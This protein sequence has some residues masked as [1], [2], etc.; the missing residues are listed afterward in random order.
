MSAAL[1]T[2]SENNHAPVKPMDAHPNLT[3]GVARR[4]LLVLPAMAAALGIGGTASAFELGAM[5]VHSTLG[6]PLRASIAYALNPHEEISSYCIYLGPGRSATGLPSAGQASVVVDNGVIRLAGTAAV[7]DPLLALQLTVDCPYAAHLS[8]E[9]V[10]FIDP[11]AAVSAAEPVNVRA[12]REQ[13]RPA[14]AAAEAP[15]ARASAAARAPI[16]AST[17]YRVQPGDTLSGIAQRL[18]GRSITIWQAVEAL[19]AANPDAF[20]GGNRDFLK[21]GAVLRVPD[22]IYGAD[23]HPIARPATVTQSAPAE[24]SSPPAPASTAYSGYRSASAQIE[25]ARAAREVAPAARS[26]AGTPSPVPAAAPARDIQA[27]DGPFVGPAEP[28]VTG[29]AASAERAPAAVLPEGTPFAPPLARVPAESGGA[30]SWLIWL[31]GSGIALILALLLGRPLR[32]RFDGAAEVPFIGERPATP[33]ESAPPAVTRTPEPVPDTSGLEVDFHFGEAEA[34]GVELDGDV[35]NGSG[36]QGSGEL[37]IAQDFGFSASD[38]LEL[39]LDIEFPEEQPAAEGAATNVLPTMAR[40]GD[41]IVE[42][43]VPPGSEETGEYDVSMIVD[44]TQ[45]PLPDDTTRDLHAIELDTGEPAQ[46]EEEDPFTL[47]RE[48][49]YK[50]LEQDYQEELTATQALNSRLEDAARDL[51]L[52]LGADEAASP[53]A[54]TAEFPT[55][56]SD[57]T[58]P[59]PTTA[60]ALAEADTVE[61][62]ATSDDE[63]TGVN[64]E[65]KDYPAA[66]ND[67]TAEMETASASADTAK[68]KKVS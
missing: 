17:A 13:V 58:A 46:E 5:E 38:G 9:Y 3:P 7:S 50:I 8:R 49:D 67:A 44:A 55:L 62:P 68:K 66:V 32:K 16:A 29:G 51:A 40:E 27:E 19:F 43:E 31:G 28:P 63:D 57:A 53:D 54:P 4:S 34:G 65:L 24:A 10:A 52:R 48:M 60:V 64:E 39:G 42:N 37:D 2:K 15:P 1:Q 14:R 45:Q 35:A 47:S 22:A 59:H 26:S 33:R 21:A 23:G 18:S 20:V 6:Q 12:P 56:S 41:V 61:M 25:S 30:W 36:F 11:P